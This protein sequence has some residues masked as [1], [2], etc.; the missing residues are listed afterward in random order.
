MAYYS[1]KNNCEDEEMYLIPLIEM[2][3]KGKCP[4]DF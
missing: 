2:L 4:A 3:K 1:L